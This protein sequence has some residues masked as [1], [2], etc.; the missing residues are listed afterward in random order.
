MFIVQRHPAFLA[1]MDAI[2]DRRSD[3][4]LGGPGRAIRRGINEL[5]GMLEVRDEPPP[6]SHGKQLSGIRFDLWELRWPPVVQ[7]S[8]PIAGSGD[9]IIRVLYGYARPAGDPT[10]SDMAV[11]LL[12]GD[13]SRT[14]DTWYDTAVPEAERRLEDWCDEHLAFVPRERDA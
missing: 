14:V 11:I 9:P 5:I 1:W 2:V 10:L 8:G 4:F 12:G 3:E 13:K 6:V 7:G